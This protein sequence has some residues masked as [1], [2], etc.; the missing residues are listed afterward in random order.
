MKAITSLKILTH[1]AKFC[2]L[3]NYGGLPI[4]LFGNIILAMSKRAQKSLFFACLLIFFIVAPILVLY[5]QGYRFDLKER[6]ITQTG[7]IFIKATPKQAQIYLDG[8]LSKTTDFFFGSALIENLFP[9][10]YGIMVQKEGF[11]SWEKN[12]EVREK[13]V[14]EARNIILFPENTY[15]SSLAQNVQKFWFS[16]NG[17]RIVLKESKEDSF[18][19]FITSDIF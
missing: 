18:P 5:T 8:Q 17:R 10:R 3:I 2:K 13:E 6:K 4:R 14:T 7:G 19:T 1:L 15:Y 9:K 16:P 11:Y 12:L